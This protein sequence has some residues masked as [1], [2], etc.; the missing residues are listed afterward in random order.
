MW[1]KLRLNVALNAIFFTI[2]VPE[3]TDRQRAGLS[4][5][6]VH[7]VTY[8]SLRFSQL[9]HS[10]SAAVRGRP[11]MPLLGHLSIN[12]RVEQVLDN[13][14]ILRHS[15]D[16]FLFVWRSEFIRSPSNRAATS[17]FCRFLSLVNTRGVGTFQ[18]VGS[19]KSKHR[20][21]LG[22]DIGEGVSTAD[23]GICGAS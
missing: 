7:C 21:R 6:P 1:R 18:R 11:V 23:C 4:S 13:Q 17:A 20:R 12:Q 9:L 15:V 10:Y 5:Y 2:A 14:P 16:P 3:V 19:A 22:E 8:V